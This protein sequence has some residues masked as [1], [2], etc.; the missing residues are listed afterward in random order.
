M[1]SQAANVRGVSLFLLSGAV[2]LG[3]FAAPIPHGGKWTV[4]FDVW[5]KSLTKGWP[6]AVG[7]Y[8]LLCILGGAFASLAALRSPSPLLQDFRSG[9]VLATL[10]CIGGILALALYFQAGPEWLLA[11]PVGGLMWN[12]LIF[13][14]GVIIPLGAAFLNVMVSYGLLE[15]VGSLM[16]PVMRP[17]F[18]LPGRAALDDLM[19]WLGSYSVGL[20]VT[21]K[22]MLEGRYSRRE[23]F[24]IVTGF[25]TVSI[26][27]VGVVAG[28]LDL[29]HVFPLLMA[30][31][32]FAVYFLAAIQARI[33]P[34]TG[35]ADDHICPPPPEPDTRGGILRSGWEQAMR[36]ASSAPPLHKAL[37]NGFREG[38]VLAMGILGTILAV[39]TSALLIAAHTPVF[40]WLGAPLVPALEMLGF[41]DAGLLA[42]AV[43]A[44]IAEMY[45][46]ALLAKDADLPGRF[47]IASLSVSQ[48]VFFSSLGPM[49]MDMFRE[50]PIR[51]HHLLGIFALRTAILVPLLAGVVW[52]L[53][54]LGLLI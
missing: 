7:L 19:S 5:V 11:K 26:G 17:L 16:R 50:I 13:S 31:Y 34:A 14:V 1:T 42:P 46:P 47:F 12:V 23:A 3:F 51:L 43:V 15:L 10:R 44:G 29:L 32:C 21:R 41:K 25:S 40:I 2:G 33:W 36:R 8:C 52:L 54:R 48:L 39:G 22:L 53:E 18:R 49:M 28:T 30:V 6:E 20:F 4:L 38:L 45:I 27:F 37:W 24:V 9:P 35:I